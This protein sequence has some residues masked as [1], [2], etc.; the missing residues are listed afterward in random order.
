[1]NMTKGEKPEENWSGRQKNEKKM[2]KKNLE[3]TDQ[4]DKKDEQV[5]HHL[6]LDHCI[7]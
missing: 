7:A 5:F 1:M 4:A 6:L 2:R 3:K